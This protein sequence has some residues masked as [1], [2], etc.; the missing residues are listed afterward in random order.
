MLSDVK[1]ETFDKIDQ[2]RDKLRLDLGILNFENQCFQIN[3]ILIKNNFFLR[4]FELK[5][6]FHFLIKRHSQKKFVIR[7]L[8]SCIIEKFNGFNIVRLELD[9]ELRKEMSP[10]DI[11]YKPVKKYTDNIEYFFST[12]LNLAYRLSFSEGQ[13]IRHETAFQCFYCSNYYGRKN[14]WEM[15][16][17][18]C[19]GCPGFVYN[20]ECVKNVK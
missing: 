15:H 13:K 17:Q 5:D 19:T 10:I 1:P 18:H 4:V 12:E 14:R 11:L 3:R 20:F 8:S 2:L 7:D 16:L 9:K 6:K